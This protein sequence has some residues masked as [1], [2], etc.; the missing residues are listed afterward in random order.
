MPGP[1]ILLVDDDEDVR[2]M[3]AEVLRHAGFEVLTANGGPQAAELL[4]HGERFAALV[5]DQ[6]MPDLDGLKLME[7]A[8]RLQPGLPCLLMTG[9]MDEFDGDAAVLRK[10]FRAANLVAAVQELL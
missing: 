5:T 2:E 6:S 8:I 7:M 1:R 3:S 9:Y 10:P 4:R